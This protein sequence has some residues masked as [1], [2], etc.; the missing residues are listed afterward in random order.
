MHD[1]DLQKQSKIFPDIS[2]C[3]VRRV[4]F[5]DLFE[6]LSTWVSDCP[7]A[8]DFGRGSFCRH[9]AAPEIFARSES[10]KDKPA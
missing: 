5:G 3:L 1:D 6:C 8:I 10:I 4:G 2:R 7:H 9:P